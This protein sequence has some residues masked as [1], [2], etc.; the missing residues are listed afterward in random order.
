M[1]YP[2]TVQEAAAGS[3]EV[4]DEQRAE[5]MRWIDALDRI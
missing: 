1:K 2:V 5:F 4:S 3:K